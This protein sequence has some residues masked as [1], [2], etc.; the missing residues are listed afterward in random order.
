MGQAAIGVLLV[1]NETLLFTD[2]LAKAMD[3]EPSV[4]LISKPLSLDEA[5]ELCREQRP[6]VVLLEASEMSEGSVG[7]LVRTLAQAC[8]E[9]PVIL[10]ADSEVDDSF[11][12]AGM[13]A[14]ARGIVDGTARIEE[15]VGAVQAAAAGHRVV[16]QDRFVTAVEVTARA[17]ER[18]RDRAERTSQLTQR[19]RDVMGFLGQAMSNAD[20]ADRLSISPRT[21]DKHVQHIIRK[22]GVKSRLGVAILASRMGESTEDD[23][24][25]TA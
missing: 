14:G 19:E 9:V 10:L 13:E 21:V 18:K 3:S 11:L 5:L 8:D 1:R 20:I 15:V 17:R 22:L 16:D 7:G 6:E 25:G 24:L 23:A 4:R 12:V 2:A